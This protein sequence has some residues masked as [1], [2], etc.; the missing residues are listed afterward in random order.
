MADGSIEIITGRERRRRWSVTEKLRIV[1]ESHERGARVSGVAA[2]HDICAS[3]LHGWRRQVREGR[4]S[5]PAAPEFV[6]VLVSRQGD[7]PLTPDRRIAASGQ[8]TA[9]IEVVLPSG[10]RI[11]IRPGA[12]LP[13]L[14]AVISALRG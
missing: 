12:P 13:A 1:A 8:Q 7:A 5:S 9:A 10:G 3:L 11:L 2:R 6:P 14:R 4:L